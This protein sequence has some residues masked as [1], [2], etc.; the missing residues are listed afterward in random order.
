MR[1]HSAT[2]CGF[3]SFA[4]QQS[5]ELQSGLNC[6]VGPDGT[7]KSNLIAALLWVL[8]SAEDGEDPREL[9]FK[10]SHYRDP[11]LRI[12]VS[13]RYG[14]VPPRENDFEISRFEARNPDFSH[15]RINN[16]NLEPGHIPVERSEVAAQ[17]HRIGCLDSLEAAAGRGSEGQVFLLDEIDATLA[18]DEFERYCAA[19]LRLRSANQ[20]IVVTHRKEVIGSS[21][22]VVGVTMEE[23]GASKIVPMRLRSEEPRP[24]SSH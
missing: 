13:L 21:D 12:L 1:L 3:R 20:L 6:I 22:R 24:G 23:L 11:A 19:M 2:I 14:D 15:Y 4:I 7:G 9:F 5:I 16:R 10:G 18:E 8:G 17:V